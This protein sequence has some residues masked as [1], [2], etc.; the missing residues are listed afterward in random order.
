MFKS[1]T[2]PDPIRMQTTVIEQVRLSAVESKPANDGRIKTSHFFWF[3][4]I[5]G[6]LAR[7]DLTFFEWS[8]GKDVDYNGF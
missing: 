8:G 7:S 4:P 2:I 5:E 3:K 6:V 1:P